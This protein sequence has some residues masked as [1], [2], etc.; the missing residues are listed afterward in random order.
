MGGE[1]P[2]ARGTVSGQNERG[3]Q[4]SKKAQTQKEKK[5]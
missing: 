5:K 2:S 4:E 1:E 3:D